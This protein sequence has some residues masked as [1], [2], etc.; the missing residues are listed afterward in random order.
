LL[1]LCLML[2]SSTGS[3]NE[4]AGLVSTTVGAITQLIRSSELSPGDRLPSE[5]ELS[6]QFKV[7]RTVIRE[8]FRS[9]AAM[10][11]IELSAGK[12]ATVAELD[13]AALSPLIEHGVHT[14]QISIQQIYDARRTVEQRTAA[15][16]ALRCNDDQGR[17][18]LNHA[19]MMK[20]HLGSPEIVMEHD[21]GFHLAI[22][23]AARNPV[24]TLIVGAFEGITRQTWPIGWR[25]RKN[26]AEHIFM[27][28]LHSSIA[29]AIVAGDPQRAS[30][31]MAKHFDESVRALV[32]AGI[33]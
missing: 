7:S 20:A 8:A 14:E 9:L 23:K 12:R 31:L 21:L 27:L 3:F 30:E 1:G 32:V 2:Y 29:E 19:A 26:E 4:G 18:I 17:E 11:L 28:D 16:A 13:S 6:R 15:L 24:F 22:A 5:A 33:S 10:R 25:S